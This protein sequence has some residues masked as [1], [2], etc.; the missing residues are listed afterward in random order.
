MTSKFD[1]MANEKGVKD[2]KK[3]STHQVGAIMYVILKHLNKLTTVT[4]YIR[5]KSWTIREC[6]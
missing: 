4:H 3:S 5:Y 6:T 1:F 2:L